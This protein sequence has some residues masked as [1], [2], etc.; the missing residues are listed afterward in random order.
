MSAAKE[1]VAPPTH[2]TC[3]GK[4][5]PYEKMEHPR[6]WPPPQTSRSSLTRSVVQ[7]NALPADGQNYVD[8]DGEGGREAANIVEDEKSGEGEY[9]PTIARGPSYH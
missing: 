7:S 3:R 9:K 5:T 8:I 2:G 4:R 1:V 6:L